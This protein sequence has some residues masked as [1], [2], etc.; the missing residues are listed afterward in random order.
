MVILILCK[1]SI[2]VCYL[3]VLQRLFGLNFVKCE[4]SIPAILTYLEKSNVFGGCFK[5]VF[6]LDAINY[7]NLC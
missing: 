6:T 5:E 2:K 1:I 7:S 3:Q 4:A